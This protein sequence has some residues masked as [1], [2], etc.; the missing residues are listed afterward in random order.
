MNKVFLIGRLT[1]DSE[2]VDVGKGEKM[3]SKVSFTL[4]ID[5]GFG[6]KK[7]TYYINCELWGKRAVS[8]GEYRV[9]GQQVSVVG[10][11]VTGSYEN[12]EKKKVYFTNINVE[13]I[14]LLQKP[15]SKDDNSQENSG[16]KFQR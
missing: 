4:A 6:D 12:K 2:G 16:S 14:T 5:D 8:L 1:K 10:K 11:L 3:T 15:K 9:K 7:K 13:E